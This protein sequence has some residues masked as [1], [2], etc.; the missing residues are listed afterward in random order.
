MPHEATPFA[1]VVRFTVRPGCGA[2]FDQLIA[3]TAAGI[4]A[5]EPGTLVYA[6]HQ[7]D[8]APRERIFYELYRDRAAFDDHEAQPHTRRF[9]AER[10]PLLESTLVDFL[11]LSDGKLP[12]VPSSLRATSGAQDIPDE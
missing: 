7:V 6:C 1:L 5:H 10:E 12:L 3:R 8:G 11:A 9:L 2:D 4:R